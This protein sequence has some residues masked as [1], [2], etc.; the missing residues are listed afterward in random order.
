MTFAHWLVVLSAFIIILGAFAYIRDTLKG[1]TKPNRVTWAMWALASLTGVGAALSAGAY[2][3]AAVRIFLG[4][5]LP[6][7]VFL[8]SFVNS[9][10]YWKLTAFDFLCGVS[11]VLALIVWIAIDSPKAAVLFAVAGD[12]FATLPTVKKAW[13]NPETETGFAYIAG[14]VSVILIIPSIPNW[15]IENAAFQIYFITANALLLFLV[16]R[17]KLSSL[18]YQN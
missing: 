18:I 1:K 5:F 2:L 3:W 7:L 10:S 9:K 6:L 11:S 12:T 17:K 8:A 4:G 16:Y 14:F 13:T 15:N